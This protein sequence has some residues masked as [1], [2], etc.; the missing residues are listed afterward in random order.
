MELKALDK[1]Q[2]GGDQALTVTPIPRNSQ[3]LGDEPIITTMEKK[4]A[5]Y[6]GMNRFCF[7]FS[8]MLFYHALDECFI[9]LLEYYFLICSHIYFIFMF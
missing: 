1:G 3:D 9:C 5:T 4:K 2:N 6:M 8:L 7:M